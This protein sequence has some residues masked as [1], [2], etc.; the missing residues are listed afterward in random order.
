MRGGKRRLWKQPLCVEQIWEWWDRS[1]GWLMPKRSRPTFNRSSP[2]RSRVSSGWRR[3]RAASRAAARCSRPRRCSGWRRRR[4][5]SGRRR[6]PLPLER[7]P[8]V[9]GASAT[10]QTIMLLFLNLDLVASPSARD[11]AER[12][13]IPRAR[14][15][16]K[17]RN[18][19]VEFL[20]ARLD[21]VGR[22]GA[23][24]TALAQARLPGRARRR[25]R[26][27]FEPRSH[28]SVPP[29]HH[30]DRPQPGHRRRS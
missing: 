19:A 10:A 28:S 30:Q 26:G 24:A 11:L 20:E 8:Q 27:T 25:R 7:D 12:A 29:R 6:G 5:L 14:A 1:A 4:R 13:R 22:F 17:P 3:W 9:C 2:S 16:L 23:L 18:V 15:G 21:D